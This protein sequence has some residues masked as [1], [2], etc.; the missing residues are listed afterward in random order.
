[1]KYSTSASDWFI[2]NRPPDKDGLIMDIPGFWTLKQLIL[3][4]RRIGFGTKLSEPILILTHHKIATR[5]MTRVFHPLA[6]RR[7]FRFKRLLGKVSDIP[8]NCDILQLTHSVVE[9]ELLDKGYRGV[10]IIRD[11]RDVIVSGYLY[12][13]RCG[14][15]E[16]WCLNED[17]SDDDFRFPT[18]PWPVDCQNIEARRDFVSLF[19]G[20]SYQTKITELDKEAGIVFEM[21]GYAGVTIN[22]MLDWKERSEIL[23]IKMED[24]VADFD[25]VF[26][27]I[28]RWVKFE[29]K[30]IK[31]ELVWAQAQDLNRMSVRDIK[32]NSHIST[33]KLTKWKEFFTPEIIEEYT[34]RFGD[35]HCILGY[36]EF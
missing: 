32:E 17:F 1:M 27:R 16:P 3:N 6:K 14:D 13:Q 8:N 29:E 19:N 10:R 24:I 23:T 22:T 18:V 15:H 4:I 30:V 12:H 7:G 2:L 25:V 5:L 33:G 35:A 31:E 21:D 36:D 34:N 28:F 20:K 26:E 11:P 9:D